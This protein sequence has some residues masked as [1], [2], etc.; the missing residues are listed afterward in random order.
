MKPRR[1]TTTLRSATVTLLSATV[2]LLFATVTLLFATVLSTAACGQGPRSQ[3]AAD[4]DPHPEPPEA[5]SLLGRPL[6]RPALDGERLERLVADLAAAQASYDADPSDEDA[7]I[8]LGR[9]TAYLSRYND[10]V[11]IY[12][13]G[14]ELH[15]DSYK[16]LRH[17]GHRYISLRRFEEAVVDLSRAAE[18]AADHEDEIEPDG[19]PNRLNQPLSSVKF[20]IWYHLAL[21]HYL[22]GDNEA[23]LDAWASCMQVSTNPDLLVATSDWMYMTL[24]RLGRRDEA[25]ELLRPIHADLDI[26]ENDAYHRRLLMYRGEVAPEELLDLRADNDPDVAL[27]IATQGYGVGN[28][29][30]A[31]G[32][33]ETAREIFLRIVDGTSWAAFGYIAAEADLAR[34][35]PLE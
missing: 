35:G 17:R 16:L 15:P 4:A 6:Y 19:I 5:T 7:I 25:A 22:L 21:A 2:T 30:L 13:R 8:W 11:E 28:W 24:R 29:Y 26:I 27:A 23:A 10:A 1:R 31:E 12:S 32:D 14:L 33:P 18:L 9:R 3:P 20:N 34:M